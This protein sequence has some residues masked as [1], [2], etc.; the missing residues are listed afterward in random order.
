MLTPQ[1]NFSLQTLNTLAVPANADNYVAARNVAELRQ[2]LQE[3]Q[4]SKLP[5]IILG[6]GSNMVLPD[7]VHGWAIHISHSG[8]HIVREN[9][10]FVWLEVAAGEDWH[11]LV[12]YCLQHG[13]YGLE[14]LSLIPGTVGAA[15]IQNIGAYGVELASVVDQVTVIER[16]SGKQHNMARDACEFAYRDSVF[17]GRYRD[18]YVICAVTFKL[19][20][21]PHIDIRY[22]ALAQALADVDTGNITPQLV[23]DTVCCI[24]RQR[25]PDPATVPNAGSFFKNPIV[26]RAVAADLRVQYPSIVTFDVDNAHVKL[27]AAWLVDQAGWRGYSRDGVG[28]HHQQ[29]LVIVNP[30]KCSQRAILDL[31][32]D[33]QRDVR[34]KFDIALAIEPIVYLK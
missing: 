4:I 16:D 9:D 34:R 23:S 7:R 13:Y 12:Q 19:P 8:K 21:T 26:T 33:I 29:A 18:R 22:P 20:K 24:R 25:L 15:P 6:G 17:K 5:S 10:D 14:N 1:R 27:A 28:V 3:V 31:A 32:G 30:G 11:A 2:A